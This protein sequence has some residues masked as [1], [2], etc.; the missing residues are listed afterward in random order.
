[1]AHERSEPRVSVVIPTYNRAG[2]LP[3]A[4]DSALEQTVE[5]IE[6]IVVDDGSTDDTPAVLASYDD[7]R[8]Q[9]VVHADNQGANVARNTGIDHAR[10]EYI[11]FLD[12]DDEWRPEKL[13]RQ[14]ETLETRS[15]EWVAAY[16]DTAL[17]LPETS[18]KLRG[19]AAAVLS[20]SD[21]EPTREGG[22]ELIGEILADNVQPGAGST[23]LVETEV[24]RDIGGFDEELDR[25]QDPE[26]CLRI[27]KEG[28]LAYVDDELVVREETGHPPAAVIKAADQQYLS[29][30]EDEVDRFEAAGYDI[31]ARHNLLLA[32][33]YLAEGR[34][35]RGAWHLR[36]ATPSRRRYPGLCWAAGTGVRRRPKTVV[37][38][39]F[40]FAL[41]TVGL[42]TAA[43]R[44]PLCSPTAN[45]PDVDE[46]STDAGSTLA[47]SES[48]DE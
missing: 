47:D 12:S 39:A 34:F 42:V 30:Y 31:R 36:S 16:C 32:K 11:A 23:L 40:L 33:R 44:I 43:S 13:D 8:V 26:F 17:E 37:A 9:P 25:F 4:I 28:K 35:L 46:F 45:S 27:L 2:T 24:A 1:M 10:G 14:L 5:E 20:R 38:T 19:L 18:D 7:P 6:V 48:A 22:E 3:T 29:R 15:E 41:L 21:A